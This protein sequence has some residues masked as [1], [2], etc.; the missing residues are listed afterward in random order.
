[1][2]NPDYIS[3]HII[4][5]HRHAVCNLNTKQNTLIV[6]YNG[7]CNSGTKIR[8]QHKHFVCMFLYRQINLLL[9]NGCSSGYFFRVSTR[10]FACK[11]AVVCFLNMSGCISVSIKLT[12]QDA[13]FMMHDVFILYL[14]SCILYLADIETPLESNL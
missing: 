6:S 5:K 3:L 2:N 7:I 1:M 9:I 12:M 8:I 4:Q 14:V 13:R 10:R 11:K